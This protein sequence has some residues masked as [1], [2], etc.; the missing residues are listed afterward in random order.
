MKKII[1]CAMIFA[2]PL[3]LSNCKK[4]CSNDD[5]VNA[6]N[7]LNEAASELNADPTSVAK[8]NAYKAAAEDWIDEVD[9]CDGV[10]AQDIQDVQDAIDSIDCQ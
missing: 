3:L 1:F 5:V 7:A 9:G 4:S 2:L 10:T 6:T 8:C